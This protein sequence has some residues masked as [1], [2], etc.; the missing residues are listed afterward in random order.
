MYAPTQSLSLTELKILKLL[1]T[2]L[3][4]EGIKIVKVE[5][6]GKT[7]F[8]SL[9]TALLFSLQNIVYGGWTISVMAIPLL[10]YLVGLINTYMQGI[11]PDLERDIYLLF[12]AREFIVG[13]IIAI[14][15][16][17]IFLLAA[18]QFLKERAKGTRFI[19]TGLYSLVRH[20]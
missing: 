8:K 19:K 7:Y 15:G 11:S 2:N 12:F 17:V 13:R 10:P 18:F 9:I 16:V 3:H 1:P 5:G 20:P 14:A 6:K 4:F